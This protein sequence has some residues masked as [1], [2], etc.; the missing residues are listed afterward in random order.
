ME[1]NQYFDEVDEKE[2][3]QKQ[4]K[5]KRACSKLFR[6]IKDIPGLKELASYLAIY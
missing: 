2:K 5:P 3:R 4:H 1:N 6:T